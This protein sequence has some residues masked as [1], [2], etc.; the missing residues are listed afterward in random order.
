NM[1]KNKEDAGFTA[2]TTI[3]RS[4]FGIGNLVPAV[5]DQVDLYIE[6]ETLKQ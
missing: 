1:M 5:S 6:A 2:T 3:K 4:D